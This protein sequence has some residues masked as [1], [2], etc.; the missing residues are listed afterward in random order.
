MSRSTAS[1]HLSK[2]CGVSRSL[3]SFTFARIHCAESVKSG[4]EHAEMACVRL[5]LFSWRRSHCFHTTFE[6]P[7]V[8]TTPKCKCNSPFLKPDLCVKQR[9]TLMSTDSIL[10]QILQRSIMSTNKFGIT[11]PA[12]NGGQSSSELR[13]PQCSRQQVQHRRLRGEQ[14]HLRREGNMSG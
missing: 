8:K 3:S 12:S 5:R 13:N 10:N 14:H 1:P 6:I 11:R 9:C 7:S 2:R 4:R